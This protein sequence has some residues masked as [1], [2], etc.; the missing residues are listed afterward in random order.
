MGSKR[1]PRPAMWQKPLF[2][3]CVALSLGAPICYFDWV[4]VDLFVVSKDEQQVRNDESR[5]P[6]DGKHG[7]RER[8][9]TPLTLYTF[10]FAGCQH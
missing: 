10:V 2:L 5:T 6:I 7:L 3:V 9:L 4:V 8:L 1:N